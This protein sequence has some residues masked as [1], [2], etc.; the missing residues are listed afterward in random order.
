MI[1]TPQNI[2]K[3]FFD[4]FEGELTT[5]ERKELEQFVLEN[6]AYHEDFK[7]WSKAYA[8]DNEVPAYVASA[9]LFVKVAFYET[10]MFRMIATF[11]LVVGFSI[12][13][14]YTYIN[15]TQDQAESASYVKVNYGLLSDSV[16]SSDNSEVAWKEWISGQYIAVPRAIITESIEQGTSSLEADDDLTHF[17]VFNETQAEPSTATSDAEDVGT[18]ATQ[19]KR[20]FSAVYTDFNVHTRADYTLTERSLPNGYRFLDYRNQS[21]R[22]VVTTKALKREKEM[23]I[24]EI[25]ESN[26]EKSSNGKRKSLVD[27]IR[28]MELGLLNINDPIFEIA[29]YQPLTLNPS[30]AGQMGFTRVQTNFRNQYGLADGSLNMGGIAMDG[31][32]NKLKAGVAL[33]FQTMKFDEAQFTSV[34]AVYSQKIEL[35]RKIILGAS[36][37]YQLSQSTGM[38]NRSFEWIPGS[39]VSA[40]QWNNQTNSLRHNVG[41]SGWLNSNHG[42]LGINVF[43]LLGNSLLISEQGGYL[44]QINVSA[45]AGTDYKKSIYSTFVVSPYVVFNKFGDRKELWM[46]TSLRYK[47]LVVGITGSSLLSGKGYVGIQKSSMRLVYGYDRM[48]S[49]LANTHIGSHEISLRLLIGAKYNNWSR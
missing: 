29:N 13:G 42:Y 6:P 4:Y 21:V 18:V 23:N 11:L 33:N 48:K 20:I 40:T 17:A 14:Y 31:Y 7:S 22:G 34:S 12:G 46:G 47:S 27:Q 32:L 45:Q 49:E 15:F 5:L 19:V 1:I 44:N 10:A 25:T 43:N 8:H 38:L 37:E 16:E 30:M 2:E 9:D 41:V 36:A 24:A 35:T 39:V 26:P 28:S 3:W